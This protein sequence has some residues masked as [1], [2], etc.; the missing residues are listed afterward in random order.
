MKNY[1]NY[2]AYLKGRKIRPV[3]RNL[4]D[5]TGIDLSGGWGIP[6]ITKFQ[7][8]FRDYNISV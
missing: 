2:K 7:E 6:E 5:T 3:V 4:L 8:R 1:S